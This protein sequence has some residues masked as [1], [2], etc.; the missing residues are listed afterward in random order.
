MMIFANLKAL[1]AHCCMR[2][3]QKKSDSSSFLT[4]CHYVYLLAIIINI[5]V[6]SYEFI[7]GFSWKALRSAFYF[8]KF[9]GFVEILENYHRHADIILLTI[10]ILPRKL[11]NKGL[12]YSNVMSILYEYRK[13]NKNLNTF[14]RL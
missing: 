8:Q 6:S 2:F 10:H 1:P 11:S 14:I 5:G 7:N 12:G 4:L 3:S 13:G 9:N